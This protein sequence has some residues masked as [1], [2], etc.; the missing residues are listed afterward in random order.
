MLNPFDVNNDSVS[1]LFIS[2][3]PYHRLWD[4][5]MSAIIDEL[6]LFGFDMP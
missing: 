5:A 1:T 2:F 4:R 6:R 3:Q